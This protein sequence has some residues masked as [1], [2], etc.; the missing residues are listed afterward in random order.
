MKT[1]LVFDFTYEHSINKV[2]H[3]CQHIFDFYS[4]TSKNRLGTLVCHKSET[5]IRPNY[6]GSVL[7]IDFLEVTNKNQGF[8]TKVLKFAE[9]YS[10]QIGCKGF[11]TLKADGSYMPEKIPHIFYRKFGFSTLEKNT[12]KKLD[13]F[14]KQKTNATIHDFPCLLMHYPP[15]TDTK[16]SLLKKIVP[17]NEQTVCE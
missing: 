3:P 14:I 8:G 2:M 1:N 6:E 16:T 7:A 11:L 15:S 4:G 9:E 10:K 12:D 5:K 17:V 13:T